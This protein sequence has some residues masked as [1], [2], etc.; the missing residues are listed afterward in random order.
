MAA[1]WQ[2]VAGT[3]SPHSRVPAFWGIAY[4]AR[5]HFVE[6]GFMNEIIWLTVDEMA[7][8]NEE[9]GASASDGLEPLTIAA[10]H[11]VEEGSL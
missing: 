11:V 5:A 6:E 10:T 1:K 2:C 8:K 4:N 7:V 9:T 3:L